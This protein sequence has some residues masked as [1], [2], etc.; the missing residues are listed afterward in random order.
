MK[1]FFIILLLSLAVLGCS[2]KEERRDSLIANAEKL[3]AQDKC[4]EA[5]IEARNAIKLDPNAAGAYL[6][7]GR[8]EMK[9]QNWRGA[10]GSF[11]RVLELEPDNLVAMESMSRLYLMAN[12]LENAK[13]LSEKLLAVDPAS[14]NYKII[15]A[16]VALREKHIMAAEKLLLEVLAAEAYNE[17]ATIGLATAY[18]ENGQLDK[19]EALMLDALKHRQDS[20]V[21][22]NYLANISMRGKKFAEAATYLEAMRAL[23]PDNDAVTMRLAD[24]YMLTERQNDAMALLKD[25]LAKTPGKD[26]IRT[27]LAEIFYGAGDVESGLAVLDQAPKMTAPIRFSKASGLMR[28]NRSDEAIAELQSISNAPEAGP[29]GLAAKQR[30]AEIYV[31]QNKTDAALA[32]LNEVVKRN[33]ND[34]KA[35]ALRGRIFYLRGSYTE[36]VADLRIVLRDNPK[37]A[38]SALALAESQRS[39]GTPKLAEETLKASIA[40]SPSYMPSYLL[41]SALQRVGGNNS[42]ALETIKSGA[43]KTDSPEL[44]F[45]YVDQL[46]MSQDYKTARAYLDKL[47]ARE[48]LF[49]QATMRKA[50]L[51][52]EQKQYR[53]ARDFYAAVLAKNPDYGQAAEGYVLM[54]VAAGRNSQALAW[55]KKRADERPEDPSAMALLGEVNRENKKIP[56]AIQNFKD[57][58]IL[59]PRWEQPYIRII[60]LYRQQNK[61]DEAVSY[62]RA[63]WENNPDNYTPAVI[64]SSYYESI[65]EFAKAEEIYRQVLAR[66]ADLRAVENN[67][68]YII[69]QHNA[70]PERLNEALQLALNAAAT[71]SP[72]A[73][74]TLGWVYYKQNKLPEALESINKAY[75]AGGD[76]S[77]AIS[78]HLAVV[79]HAMGNAAE[80]KNILQELL[81]SKKD[82]DEKQDAEKLL[83][84]L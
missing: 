26:S 55:A 78:Y 22:L 12:D 83:K 79:H 36:A 30:L 21:F 31:L 67:L 53:E 80:A 40:E 60:Q 81:N 45:A 38:S 28:L 34:N 37:D 29:T 4:A 9:E 84:Q 62:L 15:R 73:L 72:Q 54:E 47:A 23:Q 14:I 63:A 43:E 18:M 17:E 76:K 68:A 51:A 48:D 56:Q 71:G 11:N 7:L 44:H 6:V 35:L 13:K 24:M 70:T 32:E 2:S 25:V 66:T 46:V 19:A 41:L 65:K 39:L 16:G 20:L 1:R 8:C 57:A 52:A 3:A 74:D 42:A 61:A 77:P 49:L 10:F 50:A 5:R 33:P 75:Q 27:R 58:S 82:F 59:A 64:L 69:T